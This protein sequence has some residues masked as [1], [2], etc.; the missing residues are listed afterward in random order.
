MIRQTSGS[1]QTRGFNMRNW[2]AGAVAVTAALA[3]AIAI[4]TTGASASNGSHV[5]PWGLVR[6]ADH[7]GAA[8]GRDGRRPE[9][10]VPYQ[11]GP[12]KALDNDGS[13]SDSVGDSFLFTE[14]LSAAGQRVGTVYAECL[15][16][17]NG[18]TMCQ[19]TLRLFGPRID[20]RQRRAERRPPAAGANRRPR[21]V[22]G[23]GWSDGRLRRQRLARRAGRLAAAPRLA[24][25]PCAGGG[26]PSPAHGRRPHRCSRC[27]GNCGCSL[28]SRLRI[29]GRGATRQL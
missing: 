21:P 6:T 29:G 8:G 11:R 13:G 15:Q 5:R 27:T 23:R 16:H 14:R 17:F 25:R 18:N 24:A 20:R 26:E 28:P 2:I 4:A 3:V 1:T 9:A 10:G 19:A 22:H 7:V 12:F